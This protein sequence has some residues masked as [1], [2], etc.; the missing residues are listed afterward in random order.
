MKSTVIMRPF[1]ARHSP[2]THASTRL[3]IAYRSDPILKPD[4]LTRLVLVSSIIHRYGTLGL[5]QFEEE[6]CVER[7]QWKRQKNTPSGGSNRDVSKNARTPLTFFPRCNWRGS[8]EVMIL[9]LLPTYAS[10][11][12][13]TGIKHRFWPR[14][15][16][17]WRLLMTI[18]GMKTDIKS[19]E[20]YCMYL[21]AIRE[22]SRGVSERR[23]IALDETGDPGYHVLS[24]SASGE[25]WRRV[26]WNGGKSTPTSY[27]S[28]SHSHQS[29][30][31]RTTKHGWLG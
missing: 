5:C 2:S 24:G 30:Q 6:T 3:E 25:R 17:R 8:Y 13:L 18:K 4:T 7:F 19:V 1:H 22:Q 15:K 31:A 27:F 14:I 20:W 9:H 12:P 28:E 11:D 23:S 16:E 21:R 26:D 10:V 29:D